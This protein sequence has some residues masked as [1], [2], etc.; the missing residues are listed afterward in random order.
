MKIPDHLSV[1]AART[2]L[3]RQRREAGGTYCPVCDRVCK[4]YHRKI[5]A[6]QARSIILIARRVEVG[7]KFHL[8]QLLH[9]MDPSKHTAALRWW[10]LLDRNDDWPR[11]WWALTE[12]GRRFANGRMVVR[13]YVWEYDG[14]PNESDGRLVTIRTSLDEKFNFDDLWANK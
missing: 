2:I 11:G 7:E 8:R 13:E 10:G 4:E 14:E 1:K 3:R 9:G 5:N 12:E 6:E